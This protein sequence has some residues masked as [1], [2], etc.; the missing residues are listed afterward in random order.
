M[1]EAVTRSHVNRLIEGDDTTL[2]DIAAAPGPVSTIARHYT[3]DKSRATPF[4]PGN[5]L[6]FLLDLS[7]DDVTV[8]T[9]D[10]W[11]RNCGGVPRNSLVLVKL[12]PQKVSIEERRF[13]DRIIMVRITESVPTPVATEV[14]QTIF[15]IHKAQADVDMITNKYLLQWSALKGKIVGTFYDRLSATGA[16]PMEIGFGLDVDTF[17]APHSYEVFVPQAEHLSQLVNAFCDHPSPLEIGY[18]RYT[19]T[20]SVANQAKVAVTVDPTDFTGESYGHR[21]A[22]FGKTRFG[23]SNTMKVIADTILSASEPVGQII[24][25]PSGEYTYWNPQDSG[26]LAVRHATR[27]V[28]YSLRPRAMAEELAHGLSQPKTLMVNFFDQP[29]VGHSL[30]REL[31]ATELGERIPD[32]ITPVMNWEALPLNA[33]PDKASDPSGHNHFWRTMGIWWAI[34]VEAGFKPQSGLTCPVAFQKNT[35]AEIMADLALAPHLNLTKNKAGD[36]VLATD[37]PATMLP[38][39]FRKVE[40]LWRQHRD[41]KDWFEKSSDG[42][43]YFNAIETGMLDVLS[44]RIGSGARKFLRF[45]KYHAITGSDVFTEIVREALDGK[46]VFVD[47]STGDERVRKVIAKRVTQDLLAHMTHLFGTNSLNGRFVMLYFEEAHNLFPKDDRALGDD[48][49]NKVAKEGAKFNISMVYATQSITTLSPDLLKN[50]ENFIVTHLDDD[51]E[52]KELEHKRAF[53]DIASDVE[54]ITSKGYVRMKTLSLPFALPVQ[55]RK[56]EGNPLPLKRPS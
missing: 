55:I 26:C 46:S 20:P 15:Q 56:F 35:K 12:S 36:R 50:T 27:C 51:R 53:R 14:Q 34:L 10:P 21:T 45:R 52:V 23:K 2:D 5:L 9:C 19:E 42:S 29:E 3:S 4:L 37:Q 17:F 38:G 47:L 28:R 49:Y 31:W 33:C 7:Y 22:L 54:R 40:E 24:F 6:G 41:R 25:D 39:I 30:I 1:T 32:Y 44:G 8:V 43:P 48:V 18:L 16:A 13:C 11:K